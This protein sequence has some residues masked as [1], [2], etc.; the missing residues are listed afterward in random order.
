MKQESRILDS[1]AG[2]LPLRM[3]M[4][5]EWAWWLGGAVFCFLL[6]SVLMSGWPT[7]LIPNLKYP[8]TY[9]GD[10]LSYSWVAERA[11]EG[12]IFDNPRSGYPFGSNFLD[13]P[14][15]DSGTLLVLKFFGKLTGSPFIAINLYF[16]SSFAVTFIAA[17]VVMRAL[18]LRRS[19]ALTGAL[20]F[21]FIPFHFERIDHLFFTWYF[22]AP[23][24]FYTGLR[25][26]QA[27]TT[28]SEDAAERRIP[29]WLIGLGLIML[30]TFGVYYAAF[31]LIVLGVVLLTSLF[32]PMDRKG[33]RLSVAAISLV[34]AGVMLNLA[35]NIVHQ[36]REGVNREVAQ[37][38]KVDSE[39]YAFKMVQLLLPRPDH[40]SEK[41]GR[42]AR[43]YNSTF[44]P[45]NENYMSSLGFIG[46]IG[47]ISMFFVMAA[48]VAGRRINH[49]LRLVALITFVLF[50]FGT[51]GGFG[52]LFSQ[53]VTSSIRGW[54][55]ISIF[56][57]FGALLGFF[58]L[59]QSLLGKYLSGRKVAAGVIGALI[60]LFGLADQT[61]PACKDC[62]AQA[63]HNYELDHDFIVAIEKSL[64]A[65]SAVYQ[66][67]YMAFPESAPQ[68]KLGMYDPAAGF[69][70]SHL[71]KW[72]Y[73][74]MK[75]RTGD[76]FYRALAK[77][78]PEKQLDVIRRLGF[79][80]ILLDRRAYEDDGKALEQRFTE[81]LGHPS[82]LERA[83]KKVVFFALG[84]GSANQASLAGLNPTQLME[85]AGF[86]A[87]RLGVRYPSTLAQGID[88]K[89]S[90]FPTFLKDIDGIS[91]PE[92]WGRWT[93]ANISRTVNIDF[94]APLP[95]RFTLSL[96]AGPFGPNAEQDMK[97]KIGKQT[98]SFK[99]HAGSPEEYRQVV[100]LGGEQVSRIEIIPPRPM[101]PME[102]GWSSDPRKLG[103]GLTH[104]AIQ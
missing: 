94:V 42:I 55:R 97:V 57:G 79:A 45:L 85:K 66:L 33:I 48:A 77:E 29:R 16:L 86:V 24:F 101:S 90:D 5:T 14:G 88:F 74:G 10:G 32:A 26:A 37:R 56:V 83:D 18:R 38:D 69:L 40:R 41:V 80:G 64:P 96:A 3:I 82:S 28:A 98:F 78:P 59:L 76:Y 7:G 87:D 81:L 51:L 68:L 63:Q 4:R 89:R 27:S 84:A 43:N 103:V 62:G 52:S 49:N 58:M 100:D 65:G 17:Y 20:L 46:A 72:N 104:L 67:P 36:H 39:I 13:Y 22:V 61:V 102:L 25:I 73:A 91:G 9:S 54:N 31:G 30:G 60:A 50:M 53:L 11:I 15:S 1:S 23:L 93:D 6:A 92:P 44:T 8:F 70:H 2:L 19:L 35:P 21:D 75:G 12:W 95:E 34:I 71:L 47:F 99:L